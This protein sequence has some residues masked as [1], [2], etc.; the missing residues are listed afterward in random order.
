MLFKEMKEEE[1]R[2]LTE[3]QE[4]ILTPMVEADKRIY[5]GASCPQ[6]GGAPVR[7]FDLNRA[8]KSNRP[9]PRYNCKC[10]AC[11]CLFE[12]ITGI[13]IETGVTQAVD[14]ATLTPIVNPEGH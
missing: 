2:E 11:S 9:I 7:A 13:I 8:L 6:C 1:R 10:T 5:E 14:P 3:G 4:D 12:P